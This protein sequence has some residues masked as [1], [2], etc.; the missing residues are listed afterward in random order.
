[1]IPKGSK[2]VHVDITSHNHQLFGHA[3]E[4]RV[5]S[6]CQCDIRQSSRREYRDLIGV[7]MYHLD[8]KV[9]CISRI[10]E[11]SIGKPFHKCFLHDSVWI[12]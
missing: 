4:R 3:R 2:H 10:V 7:P 6:Y 9:C 5:H 11:T 1:M 12:S 8:H